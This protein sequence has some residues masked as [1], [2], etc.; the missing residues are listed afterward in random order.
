MFLSEKKKHYSILMDTNF[1][2][3]KH[4]RMIFNVGVA[5]ERRVSYTLNKIT[6]IKL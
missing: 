6:K 2:T 3:I 5:R 4:Q 1:V